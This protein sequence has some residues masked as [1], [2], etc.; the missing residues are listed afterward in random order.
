MGA[1]SDD[2]DLLAQKLAMLT[3]ALAKLGELQARADGD[4]PTSAEIEGIARGMD[5]E[6]EAALDALTAMFFLPGREQLYKDRLRNLIAADEVDIVID[7]LANR[8]SQLRMQA[9]NAERS[10]V[11]AVRG[12]AADRSGDG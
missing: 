10:E 5:G 11:V 2:P 7:E 4:A 12:P 3:L 8:R 6:V 9:M 1:R